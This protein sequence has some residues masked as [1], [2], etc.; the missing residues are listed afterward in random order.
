MYIAV[1]H[2]ENRFHYIGLLKIHYYPFQKNARQKIN[3]LYINF[4]LTFT[5]DSVKIPY[6]NPNVFQSELSMRGD[7]GGI[8]F[9]AVDFSPVFSA[10]LVH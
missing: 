10:I 9:L 2:E 6:Y 8:I 7:Y 4:L 1:L 5:L 3:E